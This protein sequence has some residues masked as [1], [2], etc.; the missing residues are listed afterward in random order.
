ML[1]RWSQRLVI[2][3][4]ALIGSVA[5]ALHPAAADATGV[6]F[7]VLTLNYQDSHGPGT[8]TFTNEGSDAATGGSLLGVTLTQAG[9]SL[10]GQG[11]AQQTEA[12]ALAFWLSDGT[13][14]VYFF[15][16]VLRL[17]LNRW[18][19]Q[20]SWQNTQAPQ[21]TDE[22]TATPLGPPVAAVP[23]RQADPALTHRRAAT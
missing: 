11:Y 17:A 23:L 16:G 4:L 15:T 14:T 3:G 9:R 6:P 19:A 12:Y 20:G 5:L 8:I 18:S 1:G 7:S 21:Q 10:T 22:W 2:L 13:G